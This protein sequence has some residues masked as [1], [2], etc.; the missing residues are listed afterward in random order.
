MNEFRFLSWDVYKISK[1]LI[2]EI[3]LITNKFPDYHNFYCFEYSRRQRE[4]LR[5]G[6]K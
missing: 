4:K 2:K 1:E 5:Q 3:Y 6:I